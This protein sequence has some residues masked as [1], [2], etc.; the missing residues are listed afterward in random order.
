MRGLGDTVRS[1][2]STHGIIGKEAHDKYVQDEIE[3]VRKET[4][5]AS[6]K[7]LEYAKKKSDAYNKVAAERDEALDTSVENMRSQTSQSQ[8]PGS[9]QL[10]A[11][12]SN[13]FI[14]SYTS[15]KAAPAQPAPPTLLQQ[16]SQFHR[17]LLSN[18]PGYRVTQSCQN[19]HNR[20]ADLLI[21]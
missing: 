2:T 6:T 13:L 4:T 21:Y 7:E 16:F 8:T 11:A 17:A 1:Y 20:L 19:N 18:F 3:R 10:D 5:E 9:V 12:K 15:Q 14:R